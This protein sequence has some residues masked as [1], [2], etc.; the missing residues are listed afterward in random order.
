MKYKVLIRLFVLGLF[1]SGTIL[2][3]IKAQDTES[4]PIPEIITSIKVSSGLDLYI[5]QGDK[6]SLKIEAEKAYLHRVITEVKGHQLRIYTEGR[7][8]WKRTT[9]PKIYVTLTDL[10]SVTSSG[11][12]DVFTKNTIKADSLVL[13]SSSGSDMYMEVDTRKLSLNST[14]GSDLKVK[15]KTIYLN[16]SAG[17][18]SDIIAEDL[19]AKYVSVKTSAGSDARVYAIERIDAHASSGSDIIVYGSPV[20]KNLKESN[21]GDIREK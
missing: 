12:S 2:S 11:G 15:G 4:R 10:K 3:T 6:V 19:A 14:S 1:T 18:G 17:S 13:N 7:L 8:N 5:T 20:T 9:L 16:A 21:G